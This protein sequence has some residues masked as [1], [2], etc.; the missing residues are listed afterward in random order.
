[1]NKNVFSLTETQYAHESHGSVLMGQQRHVP[2]DGRRS[3]CGICRVSPEDSV[4]ICMWLVVSFG[5]AAL[6]I[7]VVREDSFTR[8]ADNSVSTF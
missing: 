4:E 3:P 1:M 6:V 5:D 7:A 2:S 8:I